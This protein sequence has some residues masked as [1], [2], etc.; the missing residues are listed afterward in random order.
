LLK[1]GDSKKSPTGINID[2][3]KEYFKAINTP[4]SKFFQADDDI[5]NFN[6]YIVDCEMKIMFSELDLPFT[7]EEV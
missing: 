4:E 2:S 3:L 5:I 1:E 7:K 6:H